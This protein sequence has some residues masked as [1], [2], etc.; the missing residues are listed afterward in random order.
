[1]KK[2]NLVIINGWA[3]PIILWS[4]LISLLSNDYD[5]NIIDLNTVSN[6]CDYKSYIKSFVENKNLNNITIAAWSLGAICLLDSYNLIKERLSNIILISPTLKFTSHKETGYLYGWDDRVLRL[7]KR[8]LLTDESE[9]L[10]DFF[11]KIFSYN[12]KCFVK[13]F[14]KNYKNNDYSVAALSSGLNYLRITDIRSA[15]KIDTNAL[16]IHGLEDEICPYTAGMETLKILNNSSVL[17]VSGCG[18]APFYTN[19]NLCYEFI[20]QNT[21]GDKN[22]R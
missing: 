11:L 1:M 13:E 10:N 22:D 14:F 17:S 20:L 3:S 4:S 16:I 9:T 15:N 5:M 6:H 12:E 8:R 19:P 21:K 18:H 2:P 7:M